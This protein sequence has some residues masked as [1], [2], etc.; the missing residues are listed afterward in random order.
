MA[1]QTLQEAR[2]LCD[3]GKYTE[4]ARV[5]E[6]AL[7]T[8]GNNIDLIV[9]LGETLFTLGYYK[10]AAQVLGDG[11]DHSDELNNS[12]VAAGIMI[13]YVSRV[14]STCKFKDSLL[15]A[16]KIHKTF[17]N[18][19]EAETV[20]DATVCYMFFRLSLCLV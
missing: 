11:L 17:R 16:E 13:Y 14:Y 9:E 8:D 7:D 6:A 10:R 4:A 15:R 1:S 2:R 3:Q 18:P 5:L 20:N 19:N 12:T